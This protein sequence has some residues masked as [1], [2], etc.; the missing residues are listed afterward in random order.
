MKK[1]IYIF[2][3]VLLSFWFASDSVKSLT[4]K[5]EHLKKI[6]LSQS[7]YFYKTK[8]Y[9]QN[10][11]E[12]FYNGLE[13]NKDLKILVQTNKFKLPDLK[14]SFISDF[15]DLKGKFLNEVND[16]NWQIQLLD[17]KIKY[18][19]I[20]W[21]K[22][23]QQIA[24]LDF[25]IDS[26][27]GL[28]I[29][30]LSGLK[31]EYLG[32]INQL[33]WEIWNAIKSNVWFLNFINK[34]EKKLK[35]IFSKYEEMKQLI[36]RFSNLFLSN[37]QD[38]YTFL[39]NIKEKIR[40]K[41]NKLLSWN[42]QEIYENNQYLK[43]CAWDQIK[44]YINILI[45][46][47]IV[48]LESYFKK[49]VWLPYSKNELEYIE[50]VISVLKQKYYKD[51]KLDYQNLAED[52][53]L[54]NVYEKLI[55]TINN[56]IEEINTKLAFYNFPKSEKDIKIKLKDALNKFLND[57]LAK[58]IDDFRQFINDKKQ[59]CVIKVKEEKKLLKD[60]LDLYYDVYISS[61]SDALNKIIKLQNKIK[62][63]KSKIILPDDKKLLDNLY[64]QLEIKKIDLEIS[65]E[66]LDRFDVK[67]KNIESLIEEVLN[68][69]EKKYQEKWKSDV[70]KAKLTKA[71][72][73]IDK[74]LTTLEVA[75]ETKYLLLK[76]KK[77]FIKYLYLR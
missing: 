70:F 11:L 43:Y 29:N 57:N 24:T 9:V 35:E 51:W 44:D 22:V 41:L 55:S 20:T 25:K 45:N 68:T 76:I 7:W 30:L 34:R 32:K 10:K 1:I 77:V 12:R 28:Y 73:K 48:N 6:Y 60:I 74:I 69:L 47:F 49:L 3:L 16:I 50:N 14:K 67:Y 71:I 64:W 63:V 59:I 33:S 52:D 58:L 66:W 72:W 2:F 46:S 26:L 61:W 17:D 18:W 39:E 42:L 5:I 40:D 65:K 37:Q 53:Y 38:L 19:L 21:D 75:P 62:E 13:S 31:N 4:T 15:L 8:D 27:S 36:D 54:D 23:T 56:V